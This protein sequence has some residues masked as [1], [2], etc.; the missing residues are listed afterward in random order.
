VLP[1]PDGLDSA[2]LRK[3]AVFLENGDGTSSIVPGTIRYD[4]KGRATGIAVR[5]GASGRAS[6][7]EAEPVEALFAPYVSGYAAGSFGPQ[8][9]V[10]RAELA[11]LLAKLTPVDND[12]R[13]VGDRATAFRDVP[14]AFWAAE[15]VERASAAGWMGG[16]SDGRFSPNDSLTRAELAVVLVR[17]REAQASG[18]SRFPDAAS[19]WAASSIAA[20]EREGWITGFAD[21]SF[22]PDQSVT[23]AELIVLLNRV[24]GRPPLPEGGQSWSDVPASYWASGAIRSASQAFE[25]RRYL[26]GEVELIGK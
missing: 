12:T 13:T 24:L 6:V 3:L 17:W 4:S 15:A 16:K 1:L 5:S 14:Q 10:T 2:A 7:L 25:A 19:H 9:P 26:S 23:R 20:A 18:L 8:R 22:R 21:G 11:A